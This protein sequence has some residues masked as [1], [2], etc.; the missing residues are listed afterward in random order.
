MKRYFSSFTKLARKKGIIKA[1]IR[2]VKSARVYLNKPKFFTLLNKI[3]LARRLPV[4]AI[5]FFS[6]QKTY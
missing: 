1:G 3:D 4:L 2:S 6:V 5:S